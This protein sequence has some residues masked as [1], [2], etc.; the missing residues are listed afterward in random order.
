MNLK[1]KR[2][3]VRKLV[4]ITTRTARKMTRWRSY[5]R[6]LK[7]ELYDLWLELSEVLRQ[8]DLGEQWRSRSVCC[9][10]KDLHCLLFLLH[11]L[12]NTTLLKFSNI[13][14]NFWDVQFVFIFTVIKFGLIDLGHNNIQN[15]QLGRYIV[16]FMVGNF[17]LRRRISGAIKCNFWP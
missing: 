10:D 11:L 2:S 8:T 13:Y 12:I 3:Y 15:F 16:S 6:L 17:V 9:V 14:S 7:C 4:T 1:K 5:D